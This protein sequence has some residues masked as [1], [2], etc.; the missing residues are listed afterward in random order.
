MMTPYFWLGREAED[1]NPM[2][3]LR[4]DMERIAVSLARP[5]CDGDFENMEC[6]E[7]DGF[8]TCYF[9]GPIRELP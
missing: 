7:D 8:I 9:S 5:E 3:A 4:D 6:V 1:L 2:F